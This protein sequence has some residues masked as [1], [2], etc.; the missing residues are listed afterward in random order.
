MGESLAKSG[1][2]VSVT[3]ITDVLCFGVGVF[4]SMPVVRLFCVYTS[5]ALAIDFI[6]QVTF[7]TAV[8]CYCGKRQILLEEAHRES[9][10][11]SVISNRRC[12]VTTEFSLL[13]ASLPVEVGDDIFS[14][15]LN[16]SRGSS[17]FNKSTR[18]TK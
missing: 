15:M 3:S 2:S 18:K 13:E 8:A 6:Y 5:I 11:S 7:F 12:L 1:A 10:D 17:P 14:E 16:V 9:A 4:S